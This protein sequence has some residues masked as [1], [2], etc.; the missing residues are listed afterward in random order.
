MVNSGL[1]IELKP[2]LRKHLLNSNICSEMPLTINFFK[3]N[4][5][6]IR[7][8]NIKFRDFKYVSNGFAVA[9]PGIMYIGV[10]TQENYVL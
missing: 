7:K 10:S 4:S 8:Y 1:C 6:D 3:N 2:S 9:P 5:G